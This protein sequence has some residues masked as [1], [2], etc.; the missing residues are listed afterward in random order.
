MIL[1]VQ[2]WCNLAVDNCSIN[3]IK[4][5]KSLVK[6]RCRRQICTHEFFP[7]PVSHQLCC[8]RQM[9]QC[10]YIVKRIFEIFI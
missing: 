6:S 3:N 10:I 1:D 7:T 2:L 8:L 9:L 5:A 4:Y